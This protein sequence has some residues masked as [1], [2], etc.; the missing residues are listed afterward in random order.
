VG[1]LDWLN[2]TGVAVN[3]P[4]AVKQGMKLMTITRIVLNVHCAAK[5]AKTTT[6]GAKIALYALSVV[7]PEKKVMYMKGVPV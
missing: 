7:K 2:I 5:P 1:N 6:I 4:N 3:A